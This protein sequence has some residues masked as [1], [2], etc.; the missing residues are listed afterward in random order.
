MLRNQPP[1]HI[2]RKLKKTLIFMISGGIVTLLLLFFVIFTI[3]N[4]IANDSAKTEQTALSGVN[5]V[6]SAQ[7]D[8]TLPDNTSNIPTTLD[9]ATLVKVVAQNQPAVVRI[10]TVYCGDIKLVSGSASFSEKDACSAGVGSGSFISSD[11]Y[12]ATNGHVVAVSPKSALVDSLSSTDTAGRYLDYLV[13]AGLMEKSAAATLFTGVKNDVSTATTAL[14]ATVDLVPVATILSSNVDVQYAV[15]LSNDPV[16]ISSLNNRLVVGFTDTIVRA[17]LVAQDFDQATADQSLVSGQ[18]TSS[19]VALL[20]ASGSF[21]YVTLG[22]SSS[23]TIGDQLTAIGFPAFI[24][25]SVNTDQWQTIPSITQ[26]KVTDISSDAARSNRK[27]ISTSVPIAQ[28]ESGGPSFNNAGEQIG[29]NTYTA[30]TCADLKCFG[31]GFVRDIADLKALI[32]KNNITLKTGGVTDDWKQGLTAYTS[33]NYTEALAS[34]KKV[35]TEYPSNYLVSPLAR[36]ARE[37]VG[38]NTD[39]SS[40]FQ[41]RTVTTVVIII[42]G[43]GLLILAIII[44]I[45]I[46]YFTRKHHREESAA[47]AQMPPAPPI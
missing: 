30:L 15:Q 23:V 33:G 10:L 34:F 2:A 13:A 8:F 11:G 21:P 40:S 20:K 18:F 12:V 29:L 28:G 25:N 26:G 7:K 45:L 19:D 17:R 4:N 27:I 16:R 38:S 6:L 5:D 1:H 9:K 41:M 46:V 37:Q 47:R 35:Q 31:D 42:M 36:I 24:D 43:S 32:Q 22:T 44:T 3:T 14:E 39:T